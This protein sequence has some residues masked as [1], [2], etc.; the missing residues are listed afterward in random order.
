MHVLP[1]KEN[2]TCIRHSWRLCTRSK[3]LSEFYKKRCENFNWRS[4]QG[5]NCH[6]HRQE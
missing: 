4:S 3:F 2:R 1:K 6:S 5:R